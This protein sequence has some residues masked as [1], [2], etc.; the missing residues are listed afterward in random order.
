VSLFEA[1][2]GK[3]ERCF[4]KKKKKKKQEQRGL[5]G[6]AQAINCLCSKCKALNLSPCTSK[7]QTKKI[8]D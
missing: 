8:H 4:L 6:M 3:N 1:N 2:Q 5:V 7:K